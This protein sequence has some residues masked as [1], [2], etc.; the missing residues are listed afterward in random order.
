M[1][2]LRTLCFSTLRVAGRWVYAARL[3][4]K[5]IIDFSE[6]TPCHVLYSVS[7]RIFLSM[8]LLAHSGPSPHIQL[9]NHFSQTVGLLGRVISPPEGRYLHTG[10]HKHRKNAHT[11]FHVLSGIRTHDSR[12][13][14]SEDSLRLRQRGYCDR[15][16]EEYLILYFSILLQ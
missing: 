2:C 11:D 4:A 9:R 8:A 7:R 1:K 13:R 3:G 10:Q 15:L 12:V 16:V 5:K 14:A 6:V